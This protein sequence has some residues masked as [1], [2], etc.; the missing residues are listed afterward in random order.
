M[1]KQGSDGLHITSQVTVE[2]G[3]QIDAKDAMKDMF[4]LDAVLNK[5]MGTLKSLSQGKN[6]AQY[7]DSQAASI[8]SVY[9][10]AQKLGKIKSTQNFEGLKKAM[11]AFSAHNGADSI[12]Q[13]YTRIQEL[14]GE[15]IDTI[16]KNS[17]RL[18]SIFSVESLRE[19]FEALTLMKDHCADLDG[20][21]SKL[22][23]GDMSGLERTIEDLRREVTWLEDN[24]DAARAK[25]E[26]FE[27]GATFQK[28]KEDLEA[29]QEMTRRAQQEFASFLSTAGYAGDDIDPESRWGRFRDY[30]ANI[31]DGSLT[32]KEAIAKFRDE[33]AG[34][35]T[36]AIPEDKLDAAVNRFTEISERLESAVASISSIAGGSGSGVQEL[37]AGLRDGAEGAREFTSA[38]QQNQQSVAVLQT[39]IETLKEIVASETEVAGGAN[40]AQSAIAS[41]LNSLASLSSIGEGS[42]AELTDI[43][44]GLNSLGGMTVGSK[45]LENIGSMLT[46]LGNTP[47]LDNNILSQLSNLSFR[48]L[49]EL[50]VSGASLRHLTENLPIIASVDI[51]KLQ[52]LA[53]IDWSNLSNIKVPKSAVDN[54]QSLKD[55]FGGGMA[56]DERG[57]ATLSTSIEDAIKKAS[58]NIKL[59]IDNVELSSAAQAK[60][61]KAAIAASDKAS[62]SASS[63]GNKTA[64]RS[65]EAAARA[66][67]AEEEAAY[68]VRDAVE[69]AEAAKRRQME[70]D[71]EKVEAEARKEAQSVE[72][73]TRREIDAFNAATDAAEASAKK[74]AK[75]LSDTLDKYSPSTSN[76]SIKFAEN[77]ES[78]DRYTHAINE[79]RL[80]VEALATS[81]GL[82]HTAA[83]Q[84]AQDK[85]QAV[86]ALRD[87][88][89]A[90]ARAEEQVAAQTQR[91]NS[92]ASKIEL[93]T[94]NNPKAYA[95]M[96]TQIDAW[97][98][99][100]KSG[101]AVAD[102]TLN[103]IAEGFK[104]AS[105]Q[106]KLAGTTGKTF[107]QSL[108]AG[109][110]K[111][112]GWS[113][114][115]RSFMMVIRGFKNAVTAV[116]EVDAA[117]T[118][119][120]KVTDLTEQG[121]A[122]LYEKMT[123]M[124][125]TVGSKLSDTINSVADFS[126]LGYDAETALKL[127]E[128]ALTYF[129]VGD[130]I[131]SI[132][133]A[134]ESLISTIKAFGI[135]AENAMT[136]V[137]MFNEVGNHFAISSSGIGDAL[138]RSAAALAVAGNTIEESIGLVV[139]AN[140]VVQNPDAVGTAMKTLTMYLR[141]A[142]TEAEEA[143]IATDGMA[144]STAKL[145]EELL[146]LT[147]GKL[148][149]QLDEKTFKSSFQILKELS[150]IWDEIGEKA[151][152]VTQANILNKLGGKRNANVLSSIITNFQDA[153]D[154]S[155]MAGDSMGSAWAENEKYLNSIEGKTK[156]LQASFETFANSVIDSGIVKTFI[157]IER[158]I[159]D[160]ATAL[161]KVGALLPTIIAL[162]L[163]IK[164]FRDN[165]TANTIASKITN[166][167]AS[168]GDVAQI[169]N[170]ANAMFQSLNMMQQKLVAIS[171]TD[172]GFGEI[173]QE[174]QNF[175]QTASIATAQTGT[176]AGSFSRLKSGVSGASGA[177]GVLA[178]SMSFYV[179]AG[180]VV[181]SLIRTIVDLVKQH[182]DAIISTSEDIQKNFDD[183]ETTFER[184][185]K[186]L[187]NLREEYER[188][189]EK[190][191]EHGEQG[192][193]TADEY[194][195][196]LDIIDQIV[197]ISPEV[198]DAYT[199]E[200]AQISEYTGLIDQAIEKQNELRESQD[201]LYLS[202]GDKLFAGLNEKV[203]DLSSSLGEAGG[204]LRSA[205]WGDDWA[206]QSDKW[207]AWID[208]IKNLGMEVPMW[209]ATGDSAR[210]IQLMSDPAWAEQLV[211]NIDNVRNSLAA[212]GA[213]TAKEIDAI[214][215]ALKEYRAQM[216]TKAEYD[217]DAAKWL[218]LFAESSEQVKDVFTDSGDAIDY[219][220][221]FINGINIVA[222]SSL[223]KEQNTAALLEYASAFIQASKMLGQIEDENID[224]EAGFEAAY[225]KLRD[226]W[227]EYPA[228]VSML[229][230]VYKSMSA[231]MGD[232]DE[233][234]TIVSK[235]Y[236]QLLE[237]VGKFSNIKSFWQSITGDDA[238]IASQ[239]TKAKEFLDLVNSITGKE[240]DITDIYNDDTWM[241][242]NIE[243]YI[244]EMIDV[245]TA[246]QE[247]VEQNPGLVAQLQELAT[248][249]DDTSEAA[250]T[251]AEVADIVESVSELNRS[252]ESYDGSDD[253]KR[254]I[255]DNINEIIKAWNDL[256]KAAGEE[257]DIDQSYFGFGEDGRLDVDK[258]KKAI[259]EYKNAVINTFAVTDEGLKSPW[260]VDWLLNAEFG[261]ENAAKSIYTLKDAISALGDISEKRISGFDL[262]DITGSI[263]DAQAMAEQWN[264]ALVKLGK[265]GDTKKTWRDIFDIDPDGSLKEKAGA[266]EKIYADVVDAAIAT[267]EGLTDEQKAGLRKSL[268]DT[269]I[270][271]EDEKKAEQRAD[272]ISKAFSKISSA[273]SYLES[274]ASGDAVGAGFIDA[275]DAMYD[276]Q[277]KFGHDSINFG[278]I[279]QWD[280]AIGDFRYKTDI[281]KQLAEDSAGDIA[282]KVAESMREAGTIAAED[283]D[284]MTERI[285]TAIMAST[286]EVKSAYED[287]SN[288]ISKVKSAQ[289]F[290]ADVKS[291][292]SGEISFLEML[293]S[294]ID[295]A[296][297]LGVKLEDVFDLTTLQPSAVAVQ[298]A[299]EKAVDSLVAGKNYS[300]EF[301]KQLK[302]A[303]VASEKVATAQQKI[304]DTYSKFSSLM[305]DVSGIQKDTQLTYEKYK[306]MIEQDSRYANAIEY[307]NGMLT[308]NKQKYA[309]IS[310]EIGSELVLLAQQR[311]AQIKNSKEY[312]EYAKE[313]E[314]YGD[315]M[316]EGHLSTLRN[317]EL[318]I[319]GY[320]V[321]ANEIQNASNAFNQFLNASGETSGTMYTAVKDARKIIEDTLVNTKSDRYNKVGNEKFQL[322]YKLLIGEEVEVNTPAFEAAMKKVDRYLKDGEEGYNNFVNDL[323]QQGI[324]NQ[325]GEFN[326]TL[327]EMSNK[328][329]VTKDLVRA[330]LEEAE[331]YG[332]KI[333]WSKIDPDSAENAAEKTKTVFD[334][335]EDLGNALDDINNNKLDIGADKVTE[336]ISGANS[337]LERM[338]EI[339][340]R[341]NTSLQFASA[342]GVPSGAKG[343]LA[344]KFIPE[345]YNGNVDL[346]NRNIIPVKMLVDVG[347][348]VDDD[349]GWATLFSNGFSG[350]GVNITG[351]QAELIVGVTPITPDGTVLS[352]DQL[353]EY[354]D[355][356]FEESSKTG[357]SVQEIDAENLNLVVN[358]DTVDAEQSMD[359]AIQHFND[360]MQELHEMQED[361]DIVRASF[362]FFG[363]DVDPHGVFTT[364][365]EGANSAKDAVQS[366]SDT[367]VSTDTSTSVKNLGS[368]TT[369]ANAASTAVSNLNGKKASVTVSV[370][371]TKSGDASGDTGVGL[372][373][374]GGVA[375]AAGTRSARGGKTLV[376]ELGREIVVDAKTGRWFT[377]G[378]NGPE[379]VNI[380]KNSIVFNN[381]DTEKILRGAKVSGR[382]G[383]ALAA[384]TPNPVQAASNLINNA[385]NAIQTVGQNIWNALTGGGDNVSGNGMK[386]TKPKNNKN[387][388]AKKAEDLTEK[389]K[390][391][392]EAFEELQ[393]E[394]EHY[395]KHVD[396][397]QYVHERA[398]DYEALKK[399]YEQ[400]A[401]YYNKIY[402]A[403]MKKVE[404]MKKAGA[405]DTDPEL[406][407][408]EEAAWA[409]YQSMYEAFD[410]IRDLV[411]NALSEE[412]DK[413]QSAFKNMKDAVEQYNSTGK[414]TIDTFQSILENG[415]QYM[416]F[417]RNENGQLSINEERVR[418]LLK[419]RKNQLAIETAMAYISRIREAAQNGETETLNALV[420]ATNALGS[421]TWS[422]VKAQA[423]QLL[424]SKLITKEQ[425][426]KIM[427]NI[428]TAQKLA[429]IAEDDLSTATEDKVDEIKD[430]YSELNKQIEHYIK[431]LEYAQKVSTRFSD[432]HGME[433]A[434]SGQIAQYREI[435]KNANNAIA[436][437]VANGADDTNEALQNMEQTIWD[438]QQSIWSL[439]DTL[440]GL[441]TDAI[442]GRI[443][444]IQSGIENIKGAIDDINE[445]GMMSMDTFQSIL[446]SGLQYLQFLNIENGQL[447][448]NTDA[449]EQMIRAKK[450]QM[451]VET[452]MSYLGR[453]EE[454]L[455]AGQTEKVRELVDLNEQL[456]DSTWA[457]VY[458]KL[459]LLKTQGLSDADAAVIET[460]IKKLQAL[461]D[462]VD[463]NVAVSA[464]DN[465]EDKLANI[466]DAFEKAK[467]ELEHYIAHQEQKFAEDERAMDF[468]GMTSALQNEVDYY[469]QIYAKA[470]QSIADLQAEGADDTT[471][472]LQKIEEAAWDAY[473]SMN[474]AF[475]KMNALRVDALKAELQKLETTFSSVKAAVDEFEEHGA[476]S[477]SSFE[478]LLG[479]GIQYL[480]F[481]SKENGQYKMNADALRDYIAARKSQLSVETALQ[482][483]NEIRNALES[484]E[485]QKVKSLI[486]ASNELSTSTWNVVFARA[487]EL[488][489]LGLTDA[490]YEILIGN[491][492]KLVELTND[493]ETDLGAW[494]EASDPVEKL[495]E[496]FSDLN[497]EIE[498]Y[499]AHQE[500][501]Y[502]EHERA[503]AFA[504]MERD[505][506]NEVDYY[507]RIMAEAQRTIDEMRSN[508]A[509]DTNKSLQSIEESYWSAY[510]TM[511]EVLDKIRALR[512]DALKEEVKSLSD[513]YDQLK[514]ASEEYNKT[515]GISLDTFNSIVDGGMQYLSLLDK[516][517]DK[518]V[519]ATDRLQD[520]V[521]ARKEQLAIETAM[522]YISEIREAA[523]NGETERIN[524][525]VDATNGLSTSTWDLVYAQAAALRST[526]LSNE[527]Y[528]AIVENINKMRAIAVSVHT[529][530]TKDENELS[531]QYD[532]Q[533]DALDKILQYTEDLIRAETNDHI[534]AIKDEIEA[535]RKIIDLKKES[536]Q[537]TK[538]EADYQDEV[539]EKVKD[540]AK[541]QAK[542]D[543]LALDN[544]RSAMAERQKLMQDIK[545]K[546]D[547]LAKY[548]A[549]HAYDAQVEALEKEAD[550]Y[551]ESRQAEIEVLEK[552]I[553]SEEKL[554]QLAIER[555]RD[556]WDSLYE[557]LITWNTEQGSVINQEI[558]EAWNEALK[559]VQ[560]YG[561]YVSALSEI[562]AGING[563][564]SNMVV[565]D[566]PRYHGGGVAGD[567]GKLN[568]KEVLAVLQ[569]DELILDAPK[570]KGLYTVI[571]FVRTLGAKLGTKIGGLHGLKAID[572][573]RSAID[574]DTI[575]S[576]AGV[577]QNNNVAFS[578]TYNVNISGDVKDMEAARAYGRELA[579]TSAEVL[580]DAFNRRGINIIQTL[581]Q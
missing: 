66:L 479:N 105:T 282:A 37:A 9:Q 47:R 58:Q 249:L 221:E 427:A 165:A 142:K 457:T 136:I 80:A 56:I 254:E 85:V 263:N 452:A 517:N 534:Q 144:T 133:T 71:W 55:V 351:P 187:E 68:R 125:T 346:T 485:E 273:F 393:K 447:S 394:Y 461:S 284:V 423:A 91:A 199:K 94:S 322:G 175:A 88:L 435:I 498:H 65:A 143:G 417:L 197:N 130:G 399:D 349:G 438:A 169:N 223:T 407:A 543:M 473:N 298:N 97:I 306:A 46:T 89:N 436:E 511:Y 207:F 332:A 160:V 77:T 126:R 86:I 235:D 414:I 117:M 229:D 383:F 514:S 360:K 404:E 426:N 477:L 75:V 432:Y 454:A 265:S 110:K 510:N 114:V 535:Y 505:L 400:R 41:M 255:V 343:V 248:Q 356:L 499:I 269:F 363:E 121:Y 410:N 428:E 60:I 538:E 253:A 4:K 575:P 352:P 294:S 44:H 554:Y 171:L 43:L 158:G 573:F 124:A 268:I 100:L 431:H 279:F 456:S 481:L 425:Y 252:L 413:I 341:I 101:K 33:F 353:G 290:N 292:K 112:G 214:S 502:K 330:M 489:A 10:A 494:D 218:K 509:D 3:V 567:R 19:S 519:I 372:P 350:R 424:S 123:S 118:E 83:L 84:Y 170:Q 245:V 342:G 392:K 200:G 465:V 296:E 504:G 51:D 561:N 464:T 49:A 14:S 95:D 339:L 226:M 22:G 403:A 111:F 484:D 333:D 486:D 379:F 52:A 247:L 496:K 24:L 366:L 6:V 50:K 113:L 556:S 368:V 167:F 483:V 202:G 466:L 45:T 138:K 569:N 246:N 30:F 329:G 555:I 302:E 291:Y 369:A 257:Q 285:K 396:Q 28:T 243:R 490:E 528:E 540:I 365:E 203:K 495:A 293:E 375:S 270:S 549:E 326:T 388:P 27:S 323:I 564:T 462:M 430:D 518:Y 250:K 211:S 319:R 26:D 571:D 516:E 468:S 523:E 337:E 520:Y 168:G 307:V 459:A 289:S 570:K 445:S 204:N 104:N 119:L 129:N 159:L 183:S 120:R 401:K 475:D 23:Q 286:N 476:I 551:E 537:Q 198:V 277:E 331:Q 467:A 258:A 217:A 309:E 491:L 412:V 186:S 109:W 107:F 42:L 405:K 73:A 34:Q 419:A 240:Y 416:G 305:G 578:P 151:G 439:Y 222:D 336:D 178:H 7:W 433:E 150:A 376:G 135:E 506:Q 62:D 406:Q 532:K 409:A 196:Y 162:G 38:T 233:E 472:E 48:G 324:V 542:A 358:V 141:A 166:L 547:E 164:T 515:G 2:G 448:I 364:I 108:E 328:L 378:N 482:Y 471:E 508:G 149:I 146:A 287:L 297:A 152:D 553:S 310:Q 208:T 390:K 500:Q 539:S 576:S 21:I 122:K 422:L 487:A 74:K 437:M 20:V 513:A 61:A 503:W 304:T 210:A 455:L 266:L 230:K 36:E 354:V 106:A 227:A 408:V 236:S 295:V 546:Q 529:D 387:D 527:Q 362:D 90:T 131:D 443:D 580:S 242:G 300:A 303:A 316:D 11:N 25:V 283:V 132:S 234:I 192:S 259:L 220:D 522:K 357:K 16:N 190:A 385:W 321:L 69:A 531:E 189:N 530:L 172:S 15:T 327:D 374:L 70:S 79:A 184:N 470:Q 301:V 512:V 563:G 318:E 12:E 308:I 367:S 264:E 566:V 212:S 317:L 311:I 558:T 153:I 507:K 493:V 139:A 581:R 216:T 568:D 397:D 98:N 148:D 562:N 241:T 256:K 345:W 488:K 276:L 194:K 99:A 544:S 402:K 450:E 458:A 31:A 78:M 359:D 1:A 501:A 313:F 334:T 274:H 478:Q 338:E 39:I 179:T 446:E 206:L 219:W 137:D 154:A 391:L 340:A 370:K 272:A 314:K 116:K 526:G 312:V 239:L 103:S 288:V 63:A 463:T 373:G 415:L 442:N 267:I 550:S 411:K 261:A 215:I 559:A 161:N 177:F 434:I 29:L 76:D 140:D 281:L 232:V 533:K 380:P 474:E 156:Q 176:L 188:L 421:S 440:Y 451:A 480:T 377:V 361:W 371:Y 320:Q 444:D 260:I 395:I 347:W 355:K 521:Q 429:A 157:D 275:L 180:L 181:I 548:Q 524:K 115:S 244:N 492:N 389:L 525:L 96:K 8:E 13:Y 228:V 579:E 67:K 59:T 460:Y 577:V 469:A 560:K 557:D 102:G 315:K 418:D 574:R 32:A 325:N 398:M 195:R 251:F 57:L 453:V 182:H 134:T 64:Q 262:T 441:R 278:D 344:K 209:N 382:K 92:L 213:Y 348:D 271:Q 35:F 545:D 191:G 231:G 280:E 93:W 81:E 497:E 201:A 420:D 53:N 40:E 193:M 145:R 552:S 147:G 238:D 155:E 565:A 536:L 224:N 174:A 381:E 541:L 572:N 87:E 299:I 72:E 173:S 449:V 225:G 163:A 384:G 54:L 205:I 18:D 82:D 335:I 127:S 237:L 185:I 128:A 386:P 5:V 17:S